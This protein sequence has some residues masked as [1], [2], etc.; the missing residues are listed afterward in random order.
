M[1]VIVKK[2]SA[3]SA[4]IVFFFFTVWLSVLFFPLVL[5]L[6]FLDPPEGVLYLISMAAA[7]FIAFIYGTLGAFI[8]NL[9]THL[10]GGLKLALN[11]EEVP[12]LQT[13]TE[14]P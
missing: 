13:E 4:G 9:S 7:P 8:Y 1:N 3:V 5:I 2:V 14:T 11:V 10:S 6:L 12:P